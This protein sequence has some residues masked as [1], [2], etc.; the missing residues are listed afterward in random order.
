MT[1]RRVWPHVIL[2]KVRQAR[3]SEIQGKIQNPI[4][5]PESLGPIMRPLSA[6]HEVHEDVANLKPVAPVKNSQAVFN[7]PTLLDKAD[8]FFIVLKGSHCVYGLM[9]FLVLAVFLYIWHLNARV[10]AMEAL[11][12]AATQR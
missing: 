12:F 9:G 5:S 1:G 3:E 8:E 10:Q 4:E 6:T 11:I 2:E 7:E